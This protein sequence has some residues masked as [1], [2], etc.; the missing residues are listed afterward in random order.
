ML[1]LLRRKAQSTVI[2][3][4]IVAIILV[5]VFWGVGTNQGGGTNAIATVN[6]EPITYTDY[7]RSYDQQINQLRSQMGGNIPAG[8]LETLGLKEQ[9]L[10]SLVQKALVGQAA[11]EAGLAVSD[12]EVRD[13]IK[14]ME[15]FKSNG[16]FDVGWYKQV[17]AGNRMSA[18]DFELSMKS[19]MLTAKVMDHLNRFGGVAD[20]E[21]KDRFFYDYG[22]KQFSYVSFAA[23][24]FEKKVEVTDDELAAF[25]EETK[26][27][28]LGDPQFMMKYVL[29]PFDDSGKVKIP[30]EKILDYFDKHKD[31]YVVPEQR[32]AKHILLKVAEGDGDDAVTDKL[33]K[34]EGLLKQVRE[35]ADFAGLARLNSEDTGSAVRGGDLGFFGRGQMV[36]PFED[37]VFGMN[38]G[39]L[40]LVRSKFGFH[41]IKLEKINPLMVR[42]VDEV[43]EAIIARI[44]TGEVKNLAFEQAEGAYQKIIL[45]GSLEKYAESGGKLKETALFTRKNVPEPFKSNPQFQGAALALNQGELSSLL[46]GNKSYGIFYAQEV[47]EPA[48]PVLDKVKKKVRTDFVKQRAQ[49]MARE[50][51]DAMLVALGEGASIVDE[52]A[53]QQLEVEESPLMTRADKGGSRLAPAL[54]E[55]GL[56]LSGLAPFPDTII[57]VGNEYYVTAFRAENDPSELKFEEKKDEVRQKIDDEN[58]NI[59]LASWIAY[60]RDRAEVE[61]SPG[62]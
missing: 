28:Y 39:D 52:A 53:K 58:R 20:S 51:A 16:V 2:Q 61:V 17:L 43:R 55:S 18:T 62:F 47:R 30:E 60:L 7:Q 14:E 56:E 24:D 13:K 8:L 10:E 26:D 6:D 32:R 34:A 29:F 12:I 19:D 40:T 35:G 48:P 59:V 27:N 50:A 11:R 45:S 23:A 1:D 25:F 5:F 54:L 42:T 15:A 49:E 31:E 38:E 9:I 57:T 21:L 4:I 33:K 41:V 44:K 37:A 22:E 36:P 46:E 3:V